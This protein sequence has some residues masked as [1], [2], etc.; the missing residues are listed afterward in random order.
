M[1]IQ[2]IGLKAYSNALSNFAKTERSIQSN[3]LDAQPKPERSFTDTINSS[4]QKVNEMQ[5]EKSK[6]IQSFASGE[7]Q[8]VHELMITLQKAG[9]AMKLTSAVRG[10]VMEAYRDLSKMQF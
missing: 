10:K 3:K 9:V 6:M 4:V 7:T 8:N 2:S 5:G 1:T